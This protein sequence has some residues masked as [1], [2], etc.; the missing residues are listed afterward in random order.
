MGRRGQRHHLEE[1]GA[2][3]DLLMPLSCRARMQFRD[4]TYFQHFGG[5]CHGLFPTFNF[6]VCFLTVRL[7]LWVFKGLFGEYGGSLCPWRE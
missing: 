1:G 6:D 4:P 7:E 5:D 2:L 3:Q